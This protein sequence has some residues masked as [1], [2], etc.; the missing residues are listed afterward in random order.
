M[1]RIIK[2]GLKY[3]IEFVIVVSGVF[4]GV[5]AT[6][7]Q[8]EKKIKED[9][10]K[11]LEYILEELE[12][13]KDRLQSSLEYHQALKTEFDS[14]AKTLKESDYFETYIVSTKF[15]HDRMKG[16]DGIRNANLNDTAFEAAKI[17]GIIR[18]FDFASIQHIS[19]I[20]KS[21][22]EYL[23]FGNSILNKMVN[24]NSSTKVGDVFGSVDLMT[25]DLRK[26]ESTLIE[27]ITKVQSILN[28]TKGKAAD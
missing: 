1:D 25:S 24:F 5:Y 19:E 22:N 18:E 26:H 4:L 8:N 15:K 2:K 17:S 14:I 21:Q 9:K 11:S 16:W 12:D 6:N 10:K 27:A 20:Y 28:Q 7:I 23:K 3:F 13:N